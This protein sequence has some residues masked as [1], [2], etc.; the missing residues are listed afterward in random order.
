MIRSG[1]SIAFF[2]A[3]I[4]QRKAEIDE[5]ERFTDGILYIGGANN[6]MDGLFTEDN[7]IYGAASA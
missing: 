5:M 6:G 3:E 4:G 2:N 1:G 7:Q